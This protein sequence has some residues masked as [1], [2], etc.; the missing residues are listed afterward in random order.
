MPPSLSLVL[1]GRIGSWLVSATELPG[2]QRNMSSYR[3]RREAKAAAKYELT[4][5]LSALRAFAGF[6]HNS[7]WEHV[8]MANRRAG[9]EVRIVIHSWSPEAGDVL[10]ALY[11]PAASRHEPPPE[12]DKVASQHTSMARRSRCWTR[13]VPSPTT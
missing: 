11:Q 2:A 6:T 1:H 12:I 3:D 5:R 7:L 10:D 9:A 8:V 13:Y 4:S